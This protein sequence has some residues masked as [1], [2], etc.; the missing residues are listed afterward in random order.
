MH[1]AEITEKGTRRQRRPKAFSQAELRLLILHLL[2]LHPNHGYG[3]M[4]ALRDF[5]QDVYQPSPGV[6]YPILTQLHEQQLIEQYSGDNG[7]KVFAIN[8]RG[9]ALLTENDSLVQ[10]SI[11]K[12]QRLIS[13]TKAQRH[14]KIELAFDQLKMSIYEQLLTDGKQSDETAS[15]I[16]R[17]IEQAARQIAELPVSSAPH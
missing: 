5:S 2:R 14:P 1:S 8:L 15:R 6:I 11:E 17:V 4:K 7:K 3:L 10:R 12:M 16:S 9:T 13:K